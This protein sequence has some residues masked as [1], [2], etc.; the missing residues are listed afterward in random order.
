MFSNMSLKNLYLKNLPFILFWRSL[1][2]SKDKKREEKKDR[3]EAKKKKNRKEAA[4]SW[5]ERREF[6]RVRKS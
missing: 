6:S 1:N 2:A 3:S 5:L 4:A